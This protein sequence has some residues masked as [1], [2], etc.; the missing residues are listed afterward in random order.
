MTKI[1]FTEFCFENYMWISDCGRNNCLFLI[2][3]LQSEIKNH[4]STKRVL[5]FHFFSLEL[6]ELW[7]PMPFNCKWKL[8]MLAFH[9]TSLLTQTRPCFLP[10]SILRLVMALWMDQKCRTS[11]RLKEASSKM[12]LR[13]ILKHFI[14]ILGY[15]C[16][17]PSTM[18]WHPMSM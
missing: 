1:I 14:V 2:L 6:N 4:F 9:A 17:S 10:K 12:V 3:N 5:D 16:F 13:S 7:H 8:H 18:F 11:W 15:V